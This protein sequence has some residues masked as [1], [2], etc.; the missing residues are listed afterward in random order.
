[1]TEGTTQRIPAY[2]LAMHTFRFGGQ[3]R[4]MFLGIG[5]LGMPMSALFLAERMWGAGIGMGVLSAA[6]FA[7][8]L[9]IGGRVHVDDDGITLA[10][11]LGTKRLRWSE[12][13]TVQRLAGEG[14]LVELASDNWQLWMDGVHDGK[15][16]RIV[17][18]G[19][20]VERQAEVF[21]LVERHLARIGK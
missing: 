20:G 7:F 17:L 2:V 3:A 19:S 16:V 9:A 8:G 5:I 11:K 6:I 21:A 18:S 14:A 12:V 13:E 10:L 4:W 15:S 1:M